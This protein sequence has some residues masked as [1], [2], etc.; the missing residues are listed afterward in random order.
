MAAAG[1]SNIWKERGSPPVSWSKHSSTLASAARRHQRLLPPF[2]DLISDF[3]SSFPRSCFPKRGSGY[4]PAEG[5]KNSRG[6]VRVGL[7][8]E[9][10]TILSRIERGIYVYRP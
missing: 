9:R 2:V 6:M 3:N 1:A 10:S 5:I 4:T 7:C 8:V